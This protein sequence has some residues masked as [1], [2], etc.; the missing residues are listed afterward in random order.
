VR[1]AAA[2]WLAGATVYLVSE[3]VAAASVPGYS[4]VADYIS[5][6]GSVAIMNVGA[7]VLHGILFLAGAVVV[8]RSCPVLGGVRWV[9]VLAAAANAIGNILVGA[10]RSGAAEASPH[11]HWH[12]I[13]AGMAIVGGNIAVIIAG[14][15]S[16][17]IGAPRGYRLA[18]VLIGVVGIACLL[19][20]V[21]DGASGSRLLPV[22]AVERG[23]VYSIVVWEIMTGLTILR[24]RR[25]FQR[26]AQVF[27][28]KSPGAR[29]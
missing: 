24:F 12:V 17:R 25:D 8:A 23:S 2:I 15:G 27:T 11:I 19:V 20:L 3:A 7:F 9:F 13:G 21:V 29:G 5:D 18:S 6:L 4:Y 14:V 26:S 22:G 28:P 10:F 1:T 16:R